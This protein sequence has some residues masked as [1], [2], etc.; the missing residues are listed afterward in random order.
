MFI[1]RQERFDEFL[2]HIPRHSSEDNDGQVNTALIIQSMNGHVY[3][4]KLYV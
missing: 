3:I 4:N 2:T 1:T